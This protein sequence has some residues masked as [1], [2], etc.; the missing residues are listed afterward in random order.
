MAIKGAILLG[1]AVGCGSPKTRDPAEG[2]ISFQAD[3]PGIDGPTLTVPRYTGTDALVLEAQ[4]R[5]TTG[6]D[7]HQKLIM[8]SCGGVNG[9]C[10]NQKE[11]PDLHT[12]ANFRAAIGAPCNVQPGSWTTVFDR[13]ERVGDGFTIESSSPIEIGWYQLVPGDYVDYAALGQRP[14]DNAPGFHLHLADAWVGS[15]DVV[16]ARGTFLRAYSAPDGSQIQVALAS[17]QTRWWIMSDR[18]HLFADVPSYLDRA[19]QA[20][21]DAGLIQG[22]MN[23]NGVFGYRTGRTIALLNPGRPE[24]SYLVGRLRGVLEG[25]RVPGTRMPLAN[26]PPSIPDMLALMCFLE[27]LRPTGPY[28]LANPINYAECSYS[29]NPRQLDLA[30]QGITF[31][32]RIRPL[33]NTNC[34]GC[35]SGANPPF[36]LDLLS[37]GLFNRLLASS[38][39]QPARKLVEP[40]HPETSYLFLKI[41]GDGSITGQRMPLDPTTQTPR[42]LPPDDISAVGTWITSGALND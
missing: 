41:S 38:R 34:G 22:D 6:Y 13:C 42:P 15:D 10:H 9:V 8:R 32:G 33:L 24:Q 20:V 1:V 17:L 25:E 40:G 18:R 36:G 23:R 14:P 27:K 30:G 3:R 16:Y 35:H 26:P 31:S 28:N 4:G 37:D 19:A 29:A 12:P 7:L 11:Y 21:L 5:Y 39:Q 2:E